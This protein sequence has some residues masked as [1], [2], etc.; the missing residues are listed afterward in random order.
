MSTGKTALLALAASLSAA[1]LV[2]FLAREESSRALSR[3]PGADGRSRVDPIPKPAPP[4]LAPSSKDEAGPLPK[5]GS[6]EPTPAPPSSAAPEEPRA[7]SDEEIERAERARLVARTKQEQ[8]VFQNAKLVLPRVSPAAGVIGASPGEKALVILVVDPAGKPVTDALLLGKMSGKTFRRRTK[9]GGKA[10]IEASDLG[11]ETVAPA[12]VEVLHARFGRQGP[13]SITPER[14]PVRI[15]LRSVPTG[16]V[17]G[18]IHGRPGDIP[19]SPVLTVVTRK[20]F[21]TRIPASELKK[22][23]PDGSFEAEVVPNA[24]YRVRAS[25]PGFCPSEWARADVRN[26]AQ[27]TVDLVLVR[28]ATFAGRVTLPQDLADHRRDLPLDIEVESD[29]DKPGGGTR[30]LTRVLV[31][32]DGAYSVGEVHPGW[33]RVRAT[34]LLHVGPWASVEV[35]EGETIRELTLHVDPPGDFILLRGRVIDVEGG[36][37]DATIVTLGGVARTKEDG[38][39]LMRLEEGMH[40]LSVA[41]DGYDRLTYDPTVRIPPRKEGPPRYFVVGLSSSGGDF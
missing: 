28:A 13:V 16:T 6:T 26:G 5:P 2:F 14:D 30:D 24:G 12:Q 4:S 10:T 31:G 1:A 40:S 7:P 21:A 33:H 8:N 41:A 18:K 35:A 17:Q 15:E 9:D 11:L 39:F 23:E 3:E 34:D 36:V 25:A 32:W 19:P 20:G 29:A 37:A 27:A 38:S 22:W